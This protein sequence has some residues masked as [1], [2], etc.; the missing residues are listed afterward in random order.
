MQPAHTDALPLTK[1][2]DG[3]TFGVNN[4]DN[5]V[6]EDGRQLQELG[7]RW[8]VAPGHVQVRMAHATGFDPQ[9]NLVGRG[10]GEGS[11]LERE[12]LTYLMQDGGFHRPL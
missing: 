10:R 8:P 9:Q 3:F 7:H 1:P 2:G 6:P 5:L 12:R 11:I 4:A